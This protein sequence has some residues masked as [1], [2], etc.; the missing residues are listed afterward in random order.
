MRTRTSPQRDDLKRTKKRRVKKCLNPDDD[1][2]EKEMD[3]GEKRHEEQDASHIGEGRKRKLLPFLKAFDL[4]TRVKGQLESI[5]ATMIRA[6]TEAELMTS[7]KEARRKATGLDQYKE[8]VESPKQQKYHHTEREV[9]H[10]TKLPSQ[11]Q[12]S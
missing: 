3:D 12:L 1:D 9:K 10:A 4:S 7:W 6:R 5:K 11:C 8:L 2:E